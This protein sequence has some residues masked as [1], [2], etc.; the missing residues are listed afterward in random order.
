MARIAIDRITVGSDRVEAL[1]HVVDAEYLRTSSS[2]GLPTRAVDLLPQLVR[3]RCENTDG[4]ELLREL[5]D[6]ETPHLL[7][8]VTVELMALSGSPRTLQARTSWDFSADGPG[9]FRVSLAYDDDLVA[10]G[11]LRE[12]L[13]VT[14]WLLW[15]IA[16]KPDIAAIVERLRSLRA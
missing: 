13:A 16:E 12:G 10:V 1:V 15:P 6:T 11:A 4:K 2:P 5:A 14:E 9:V 8:H 3:H 7:E